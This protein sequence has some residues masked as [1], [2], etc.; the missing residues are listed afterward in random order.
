MDDGSWYGRWGTNYIYGTWSVLCA[1]NAVG[2]DPQAPYIR[3]AVEWLKSRQLEDGGWGEDCASYWPGR[4]REVKGSAASQ[5]AWAMLG[6]MAMGEA[7][8]D[9]VRRG[10][11]EGRGRPRGGRND[12]AVRHRA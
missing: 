2:E 12:A 1:L 10:D 8:S 11:A 3:R 6:L 4:E 9:A 5:T 7:R